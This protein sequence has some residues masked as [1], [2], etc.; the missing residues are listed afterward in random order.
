VFVKSASG[1]TTESATYVGLPRAKTLAMTA[2]FHDS[3]Y[4]KVTAHAKGNGYF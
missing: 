2:F 1:A 4:K 3:E